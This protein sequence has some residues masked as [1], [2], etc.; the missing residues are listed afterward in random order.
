MSL[1]NASVER[2]QDQVNVREERENVIDDIKLN[3]VLLK[4]LQSCYVFQFSQEATTN[5]QLNQEQMHD[6]LTHRQ[7][8]HLKNR[9]NF[10]KT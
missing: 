7:V 6:I 2:V 10:K 9:I 8:C 5:I 4:V 3:P 1:I